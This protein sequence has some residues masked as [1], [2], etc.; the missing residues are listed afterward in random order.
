[1]MMRSEE[2][3]DA[4]NPCLTG[5]K[6]YPTKGVKKTPGK[7]GFKAGKKTP[8]KAGSKKVGSK[9]VKKTPGK[10]GKKT[11]SKA[12]KSGKESAGKAGAKNTPKDKPGKKTASNKATDS[13]KAAGNKKPLDSKKAAGQSKKEPASDGLSCPIGSRRLGKRGCGP[14]IEADASLGT[15]DNDVLVYNQV[16]MASGF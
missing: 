16:I 5:K 7:A 6:R 15:G 8:A 11:P 12:G 4:V 9:D 1:M 3:G 14:A 10:T 2:V 13:T